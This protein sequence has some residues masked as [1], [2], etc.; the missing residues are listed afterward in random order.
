[1]T[2]ISSQQYQWIKH[3]V[4]VHVVVFC[5]AGTEAEELKEQ[6]AA[7]SN[8]DKPRVPIFWVHQAGL[9]FV[10]ILV[11]EHQAV[12]NVSDIRDA[13]RLGKIIKAL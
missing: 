5:S 11:V 7:A 1:M 3:M 13:G 10:E 6:F 8:H 2:Y 9:P 4:P 12:F